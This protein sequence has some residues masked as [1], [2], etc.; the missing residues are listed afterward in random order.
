MVAITIAIITAHA[1]GARVWTARGLLVRGRPARR[2]RS[3]PAA[4][5]ADA[6]PS[7]SGLSEP[8]SGS[9]CP[10]CDPGV[11]GAMRRARR[12][13]KRRRRRMDSLCLG[14]QGK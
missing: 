6:G 7:E 11:K 12:R 13:E 5:G 8:L 9:A 4:D 10:G 14:Y 1:P 3:D 2:R